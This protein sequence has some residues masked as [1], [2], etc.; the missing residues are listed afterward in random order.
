MVQVNIT[1]E[2]AKFLATLINDEV[3]QHS[4]FT[5]LITAKM[6]LISGELKFNDL[7]NILKKNYSLILINRQLKD[8]SK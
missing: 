1:K 3:Y 8:T 4:D 2:E 5:D 6:E 7:N